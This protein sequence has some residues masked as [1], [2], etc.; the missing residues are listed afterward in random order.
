M[1][2]PFG[3]RCGLCLTLALAASLALS[4][5]AKAMD[6][7]NGASIDLPPPT[8][9]VSSFDKDGNF[10]TRLPFD[11]SCSGAWQ[12]LIHDDT[13][14]GAAGSGVLDANTIGQQFNAL[15]A[16]G[17]KSHLPE[18]DTLEVSGDCFYPDPQVPNVQDRL[19]FGIFYVK[20]TFVAATTTPG[21]N[22][23]KVAALQ[24]ALQSLQNQHARMLAAEAELKERNEVFCGAASVL[25]G[26][27]GINSIIRNGTHH[28]V[29]TVAEHAI[30]DSLCKSIP[31]V[32]NA[33]VDADG[34][35]GLNEQMQ[36]NLSGRIQNL[37]Q[38]AAAR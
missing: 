15:T 35:I 21:K 6:L 20:V 7:G 13:P 2:G 31:D 14:N 12:V 19:D 30:G 17:E 4:T 32:V 5:P 34:K 26:V 10:V 8:V 36:R 3:A 38:A 25:L 29:Q 16:R 33:F 18:T 1:G 28:L 22:A 27:A 11:F 9:T 37:Q 24:R 23:A